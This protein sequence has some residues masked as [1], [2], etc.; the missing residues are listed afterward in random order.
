MDSTCRHNT[1]L[2]C[3]NTSKDIQKNTKHH[4]FPLASFSLTDWRKQMVMTDTC[5][6]RSKKPPKDLCMHYTGKNISLIICSV[7]LNTSKF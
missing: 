4:Y 1:Y 7:S 3:Y 2:P 6:Y 5:G